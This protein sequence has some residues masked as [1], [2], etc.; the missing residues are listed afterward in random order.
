M[1]PPAVTSTEP[2]RDPVAARGRRGSQWWHPAW[3]T[4]AAVGLAAGAHFAARW[5]LPMPQCMLRKLT[6]LPCPTCGCTRS[7]LAWSQLD[8]VGAFRFN[9][10][11]SSLLAGLLVWLAAWSVER[12]SGVAFLGR[13]RAVAARW[14]V[15]RILVVLAVVNWIYLCLRLPR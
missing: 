6:G 2:V 5:Q 15:F 7:L 14:P 13:W 3:I 4:L 8:L 1:N 11:F 9:P 12:V 10:L